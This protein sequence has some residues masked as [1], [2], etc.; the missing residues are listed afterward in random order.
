MQLLGYQI[1]T[2]MRT[3]SW[4]QTLPTNHFENIKS[5]WRSDD[6]A[7]WQQVWS[8]PYFWLVEDESHCL[9]WSQKMKFKVCPA[10]P[11]YSYCMRQSKFLAG[12]WR[13]LD[14]DCRPELRYWLQPP[15]STETLAWPCMTWPP[16]TNHRQD[17]SARDYKLQ[18][19]SQWLCHEEYQISRQEK[20]FSRFILTC[21]G[22]LHCKLDYWFDSSEKSVGCMTFSTSALQWHH[23]H[24]FHILRDDCQFFISARSEGLLLV[25]LVIFWNV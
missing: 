17:N 9:Y 2:E 15:A 21:L 7:W 6:N 16:T 12:A 5:K 18:T 24:T 19:Q 25:D 14:W 13:T 23:W 22:P 10:P 3:S 20:I 4:V 1:L 11:Y 8:K